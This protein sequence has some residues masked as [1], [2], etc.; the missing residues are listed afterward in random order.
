MKIVI[1]GAGQVGATLAENLARENNDITIVDI[2][3]NVLR[4]LQDRLDVRTVVGTGCYPDV[5]VNA[6]IE[7][8]DMIVAVTRSDEINIVA[9]Q[10]AYSLF[11]TPTKIARIRSRN[12]NTPE[13]KNKLFNDKHVPVDVMITPEQVVTN[14][15]HKLIEQP[16]ALQ[17]LDF[18]DGVVQLVGLR[19]VEDGPLVGQ[20][21]RA[22]KEHMPDIDARVAAIYR[23]DGAIFP[24][25]DTIIEDGDEV[26]FIAAKKNIRK[27]MSELRRLEKPYRQLVIAGGG[28]IGFRLSKALEEKYNIKIIEFSDRRA[29]LL[30]EQLDKTVVLR[31]SA[32][33]QELLL[34]ENIDKTDVFIA[35][36]NDDETNIMASL[37]AKRLGARKVMTLISNPVYADLM[38]GG[39]IDI[40]ISPQQAT[41]SSLLA[42]VRK[43]DTESVHSLRRGAAEALEFI[44]HGDENSS[45]VVGRAIEDIK[46]P[47]GVTLAALVRDGEVH[48]AHHDTVIQSGDHVIVFVV[49]KEKTKAVEKLFSVGFSFF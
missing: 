37:L 12:Y 5:L 18:A 6:G 39:D 10:V 19:A 13:F 32:T 1:V 9:C 22:L 21:L 27:V 25:G 40:A 34:D 15:I 30:S 8:A 38:Q 4:A 45:K 41:I 31:G 14:Y 26:F 29:E 33:D 47:P 36:T 11:H 23:K 35:V 42:H 28:N 3:A 7:D 17:V 16:G 24:T 49:D 44:V 43:G 48:I 2:D 20:R 46:S